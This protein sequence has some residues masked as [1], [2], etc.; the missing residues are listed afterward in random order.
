MK[1]GVGTQGESILRCLSALSDILSISFFQG[2]FHGTTHGTY[3]LSSIGDGRTTTATTIAT[4]ADWGIS[5]TISD[6]LSNHTTTITGPLNCPLLW[7][8]PVNSSH[9]HTI[10]CSPEGHW[11]CQVSVTRRTTQQTMFCAATYCL[12]CGSWLIDI[13]SEQ[14]SCVADYKYKC[15]IAAISTV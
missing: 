15:C 8:T 13:T 5:D 10:C 7:K 9:S 14:W 3:S 12:L 11:P 6:A 2:Q 1:H 4:R